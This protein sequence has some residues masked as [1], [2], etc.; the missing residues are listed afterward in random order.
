MVIIETFL[1]KLFVFLYVCSTLIIN[2]H[3]LRNCLNEDYKLVPTR[4]RKLSL[5]T[6]T[7]CVLHNQQLPSERKDI[8]PDSGSILNESGSSTSILRGN[9]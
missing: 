3:V 6:A 7:S 1:V 5:C 9:E 4:V 8:R 2:S